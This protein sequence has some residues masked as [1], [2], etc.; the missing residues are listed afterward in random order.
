[1]T[2]LAELLERF[3]RGPELVAVAT[4]GASNVELDF[5]PGPGTWSVRQ[6]VSHLS[7][8]EMVGA[9]R[10]RSVIAE[11]NP[12]I[13]AYDQNAWAERLD[14]KSRRISS[15]LENFR[16]VRLENHDLLKSLPEETF[17]RTGVHSERGPLTLLDLLRIYAEHAEKHSRQML[18]VR[19]KY[20]EARAKT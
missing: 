15:A 4:T 12:A 10:F 19:R 16:R 20:K 3:R 7:D 17:R 14:Y 9:F 1:M 11:E 13:P 18:D 8:A 6:I 2:E 5:M